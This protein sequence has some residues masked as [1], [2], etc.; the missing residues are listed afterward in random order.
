MMKRFKDF[1]KPEYEEVYEGDF[2]VTKKM[3]TNGKINRKLP[4]T[5]NGDFNCSGLDL[6]TLEGCPKIIKKGFYCINNLLTDLKHCTEKIGEAFHCSFNKLT[7]LEGCPNIINNTFNC[8]ENE[9]TNLKKGPDDVHGH[10]YC[11]KNK[12]TSLEGCPIYIKGTLFHINEN[13]T[14]DLVGYP[15][16]DDLYTESKFVK[17]DFYTQ[18]ERYWKDLLQFMI[19]KKINLD[20]V[21]GWPKG[22][23]SPEVIASAKGIVKFNL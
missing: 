22:F 8:S 2:T 20:N 19:A 1:F 15:K 12:L 17:S 23:L 21:K 16:Y 7:S 11:H 18:K 9:L 14:T 6:T 13:K 3:V 10:F 4:N 5:I